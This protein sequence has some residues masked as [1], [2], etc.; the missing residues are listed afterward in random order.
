MIEEPIT[1]PTYVSVQGAA[2]ETGLS[3][4]FIRQMVNRR[5]NPLPHIKSGT[6]VLIRRDALCAFLDREEVR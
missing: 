4:T 1:L 5:H 2:D 6:K 3:T